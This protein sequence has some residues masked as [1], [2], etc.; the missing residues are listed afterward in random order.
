MGWGL[1]IDV[2]RGRGYWVLMNR[3]KGVM[4]NRGRRLG[5]AGWLVV[6]LSITWCIMHLG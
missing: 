5:L 4:S 6:C 1:W 2:H 3:M